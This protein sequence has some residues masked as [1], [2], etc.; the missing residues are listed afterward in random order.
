MNE[1]VLTLAA[2][3]ALTP[4]LVLFTQWVKDSNS[5]QIRQEK[6][7][8]EY[9]GN[10]EKRIEGL[11]RDIKEVRQELKNRDAEYLELYKDYTT[12]KAKY[13]V[14]QVDY[15]ELK[16]QSNE[17]DIQLETLKEDIRKKSLENAENLNQIT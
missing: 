1:L 9:M 2:N 12:L 14:L 5:K 10:L 11:E 17:T 7:D 6:R 3:G 8:E 15:E 16:K 4:V 13:E